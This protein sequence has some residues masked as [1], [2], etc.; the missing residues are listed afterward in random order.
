MGHNTYQVSRNICL[1]K[2]GDS[3]SI[4]EN[5]NVQSSQDDKNT[6]SIT[7]GLP[8]LQSSFVDWEDGEKL[9]DDSDGKQNKG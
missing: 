9:E 1:L 5:C 4:E 8:T 2:N 6:K 3:E 7:V